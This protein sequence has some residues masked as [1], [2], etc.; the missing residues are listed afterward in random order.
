MVFLD[1]PFD[2]DAI[3][4]ILTIFVITNSLLSPLSEDKIPS[5]C[6]V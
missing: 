2:L 5:T 1:T 4:Q 6:A 3:G